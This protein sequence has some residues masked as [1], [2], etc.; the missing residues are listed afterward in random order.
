MHSP[1]I[2][3]ADAI[4][5]A[6]PPLRTHPLGKGAGRAGGVSPAGARPAGRTDTPGRAPSAPPAGTPLPPPSRSPA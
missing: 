6:P 3:C 2:H 5:P 4:L 1:H